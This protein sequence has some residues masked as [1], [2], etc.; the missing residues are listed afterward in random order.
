MRKFQMIA[1]VI[2]SIVG[3]FL[4]IEVYQKWML[5]QSLNDKAI[6]T[7]VM[8]SQTKK[9]HVVATKQ[10]HRFDD[11]EWSQAYS[12]AGDRNKRFGS[13]DSHPKFKSKYLTWSGKEYINKD[14]LYSL[15][16]SVIKR[17]P[18]ID[19]RQDMVKLVVETSIAESQGGYFIS[20]K[21]GD[22]GIFQIR[23][24]TANSLLDWLKF[25]HKDIYDAVEKFRN[26][27]LSLAEN[28][29]KNIPYGI[30]LCISEYWRKAGPEFHKYITSI[31]D[32]GMLWKSVYNTKLGKGTVN[33]YIKKVNNYSV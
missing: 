3:I 11:K 15:A 6:Q 32:R 5:L 29:E 24:N 7:P 31:K 26:P 16:E 10:V 28:L 25:A 27:K 12:K 9:P 21:N 22:F 17:L 14:K 1:S 23:I 20:S 33:T 19:N 2:L 4:A 13:L 18:H 8:A 30:A